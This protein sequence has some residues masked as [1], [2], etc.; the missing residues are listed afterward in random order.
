MINIDFFPKKFKKIALK[1]KNFKRINNDECLMLYKTAPISYLG[2]LANYIREKLH[3]NNT[4]FNRNFHIEPTNICI[5]TCNFCSY[6]RTIK[7]K[8]DGWQLNKEQ[9]LNIILDSKNNNSTEVH[10]TGGV[11]NK[12]DLNFYCDLFK[13]IKLIKPNI[14]IKA[15]TPVELVYIFKKEKIS[16]LDGLKKLKKSGLNSLP[17]GGAEIFNYKI[18][19]MI[20]KNK[21]NANE[22]L[23]MHKIAHSINIKSNATMLYG[24]I[25]N[26]ED[27]IEH[28]SLLRSLQ[29]ETNGFQ[30]FIPLKFRNKN[31]NMSHINEVSIIEDLRNYAIARIYLD[32]FD[33]I[34]S[35]WVMIGKLIAKLSLNYGVDDI[36]G[37]IN[38]STKIYSMAGSEEKNP[39]MT[40]DELSE[41]IISSGR[42]PK[43][44]DTFYNIL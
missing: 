21:C 11:Y 9:I 1:V 38:D 26:Y 30:A 40:V 42:I 37:T 19:N 20:A 44:R 10:I 3:G 6:S 31:N 18:R 39:T 2:I 36:D 32:N 33:H 4:F 24:H 28:M 35:Y 14:H 23:N 12:Y 13:S 8:N 15:L 22:W 27:R 16:Y 43:E 7:K 29:D 17:G 25:E 41:L 34:K 5:Y